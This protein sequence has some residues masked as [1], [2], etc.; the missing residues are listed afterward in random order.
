MGE[1]LS[2]SMEDYLKAIYDLSA[3]SGRATT[4]QLAR[5]LE[6]APASI[7]GMIQKMAAYDPPLV[8][9]QKHRGVSLTPAGELAALEVIRHHRLIELFLQEV[10]GY[11]WDEVH[12]EADRLEHVISEEFEERIAQSLGF[13]LQDPHGEPIPA[14]D[15]NLPPS[16]NMRLSELRPNQTAVVERVDATNADLL[17]HLSSIGVVPKVHLHIVDYSPFDDNIHLQVG[18]E[19]EP[20]VLGSQI[21]SRIFVEV[22]PV[23]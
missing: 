20:I 21:T 4:N 12:A 3:D 17:R 5:R 14:N 15:L 7:T 8:E 13:P 1:R 16:A 18:A 2:N 9:Y 23:S 19:A 11:T 22:L 6:V 10:L